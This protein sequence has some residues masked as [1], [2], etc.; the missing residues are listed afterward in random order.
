[1]TII[2][3]LVAVALVA[4]P[5]V[6]PPVANDNFGGTY[7]RDENGII[8]ALM[9]EFDG[10]E[11]EEQIRL[12]LAYALLANQQYTILHDN[13]GSEVAE[14]TS[15]DSVSGDGLMC[16]KIRSLNGYSTITSTYNDEYVATR[17]FIVIIGE[18]GQNGPE[19]DYLPGNAALALA[20]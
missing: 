4:L 20:A 9:P 13:F 3:P 14:K 11:T 17:H 8:Q 15:Y 5:P 19:T 18:D 12:S 7:E 10:D 2:T 16:S 1:M 6:T